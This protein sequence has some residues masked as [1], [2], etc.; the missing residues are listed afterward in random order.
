MIVQNGVT[1]TIL[2]GCTIQFDDTAFDLQ[3]NGTLNVQ[4]T[5]GAPVL[6]QPSPGKSE[7]G[8]IYLLGGDADAPSSLQYA[9]L[10]KGASSYFSVTGSSMLRIEDTSAS[11]AH[12]TFRNSKYDAIHLENSNTSISNCTFQDNTED[13]I[14]MDVD[15]SPALTANTATGNGF[16]ATRVDRGTLSKD[17]VWKVSN[18]PYLIHDDITVAQDLEL[19]IEAGTV[20]QFYANS[21]DLIV[22]GTLTAVGTAAAPIVFT[23]LAIPRIRLGGAFIWEHPPEAPVWNTARF[24]TVDRTTSPTLW[25]R[26]SARKTALPPWSTARSRIPNPMV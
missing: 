5:A 17:I 15:S 25:T 7:W 16:N 2:S 14:Q 19:T 21:T 4:G 13:A 3:V 22:Q 23:S 26:C 6:F 9:I 18:L 10:E 20:I 12:C 1:L 8:G 24:A 11:I